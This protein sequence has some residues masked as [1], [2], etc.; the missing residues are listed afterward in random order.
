MDDIER[1]PSTRTVSTRFLALEWEA[2]FLRV[3]EEGDVM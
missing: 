1:R 2:R 3:R